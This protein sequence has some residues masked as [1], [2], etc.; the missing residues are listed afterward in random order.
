[1]AEIWHERLR[2]CYLI[3]ISSVLLIIYDKELL[4]YIHCNQCISHQKTQ[5]Y[6]PYSMTNICSDN[7]LPVVYHFAIFL[8]FELINKK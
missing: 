3:F 2:A 8:I 6:Q 4:E 7:K 5:L 1:M